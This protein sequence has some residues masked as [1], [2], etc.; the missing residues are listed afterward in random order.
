MS[1]LRDVYLIF[2][3]LFQALGWALSLFRILSNFVSTRSVHGAY[4]S[5]GELICL[6]QTLAF[7]EVIHGAIGIV[8]SGALLPLMQWGGRTHFLLAIVRRIHEVQELPSVF[9]TFVAWSLSEI[10]RYSHYALNCLGCSPNWMTFIRYNAFIVLYPIGLFPGEMWLMYQALPFIKKEN[11]YADTLPFSYDKFVKALLF[12]YPF[13]W[14][15]LYLHLFKQRRS[16]L[17][18]QQKKKPN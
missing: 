17:G 3:N 1:Q 15:K 18:K 2:Y 4:S 8:P 14:M 10:I 5:A 11:L 7:L 13:L 12:S 16:K 9:I 6:L